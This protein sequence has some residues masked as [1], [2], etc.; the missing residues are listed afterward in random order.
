[1]GEFFTADSGIIACLIVSAWMLGLYLDEG[2]CTVLSSIPIF[3]YEVMVIP[4]NG[5]VH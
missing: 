2:S 5:L 3:G 4:G 1:M